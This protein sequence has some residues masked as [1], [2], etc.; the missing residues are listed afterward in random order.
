VQ[1]EAVHVDE[2][3][4][5]NTQEKPKKG[6]GRQLS[7]VPRRCCACQRRWHGARKPGT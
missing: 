4:R 3:I 2:A 5:N 1:R 6:N 7:A